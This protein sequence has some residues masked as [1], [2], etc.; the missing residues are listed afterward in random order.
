[1]PRLVLLAFTMVSSFA[2]AAAPSISSGSGGGGCCSLLIIALFVY[3][4]RSGGADWLRSIAAALFPGLFGWFIWRDR[5]LGN[6]ARWTSLVFASFQV[7]FFLV[8]IVVA[9]AA[10]ALVRSLNPGG[11]YQ[12]SPLPSPL[13]TDVSTLPEDP[14]L[15][16]HPVAT[17]TSDPS[18]GKVFVNGVETGKTPLDTPLNAGKRNQVKVELTGF[19]TAE[20]T[21]TPNAREQLSM[22]FTLKSA[23]TLTVT[24]EPPGAR[25]LAERQVVLEKTPGT[26][27]SLELGETELLV[28]LPGH[29][30]A[31]QQRVLTRGETTLHV[32]LVPGV[33]IAVTSEPAQ[34]DIFLN[35]QWQGLTPAEIYVAPKGNQTLE[36]KKEGW[37]AAK[38]VFASVLRPTH[39]KVKLVDTE[40]VTAQGAVA[41]ARARYD[42][43]DA[44]L[45]K[46]QA[47][48]AKSLNPNPKL[49][50]KRIALDREM[51]KAATALEQSDAK[52]RALEDSRG[53]PP[54]RENGAEPGDE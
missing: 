25:V 43:T 46:V 39:F 36:V 32:V 22:H 8:G 13:P 41:R 5:A 4:Y 29:Q 38:K 21:G 54:P 20:Q 14:A 49:E 18:G 30:T 17:I 26:T 44:A 45:E 53:R 12:P 7:F 48:L 27:P 10:P 24:S 47:L 9:L 52:L 1:M 15:G 35:G 40:R 51:E 23:A 3:I 33:K 11:S 16:L 37:A 2:F 28:S 19:F 42:K 31:R 6:G 50:Q 34:A